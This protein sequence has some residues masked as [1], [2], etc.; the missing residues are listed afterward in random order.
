M[1]SFLRILMNIN[2]S[3]TFIFTPPVETD[4][5][6]QLFPLINLY[7]VIHIFT[8]SLLLELRIQLVHFY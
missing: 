2:Q 3:D 1:N 4:D 7:L 5:V 6:I 8:F